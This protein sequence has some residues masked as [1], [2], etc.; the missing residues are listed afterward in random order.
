[1]RL[2]AKTADNY[3]GAPRLVLARKGPK[4]RC[5]VCQVFCASVRPAGRRRSRGR[6]L[7]GY[8]R[9]RRRGRRRRCPIKSKPPPPPVRFGA[10][11]HHEPGGNGLAGLVAG[12]KKPDPPS[13]AA[14]DIMAPRKCTRG[15]PEEG[16]CHRSGILSSRVWGH[17]PSV[18]WPECRRW[19]I[20]RKTR[21]ARRFNWGPVFHCL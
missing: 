16:V 15:T 8:T 4:G 10:H 18:R 11:K 9:R 1:M 19:G 2:I 6:R 12:R 5:V 21:W 20:M 13:F 17:H 3:V 7:S 14:R